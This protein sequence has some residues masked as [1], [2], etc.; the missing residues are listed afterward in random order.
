MRPLALLA[1]A[2]LALVGASMAGP[3]DPADG[4]AAHGRAGCRWRCNHD[5]A[6]GVNAACSEALWSGDGAALAACQTREIGARDAWCADRCAD[7]PED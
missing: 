2:A 5:G 1:L 4:F 7:L 3:A 6:R